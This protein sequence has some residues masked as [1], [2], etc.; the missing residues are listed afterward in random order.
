MEFQ[1]CVG[2]LSVLGR[3]ELAKFIAL[4]LLEVT[5]RART[6]YEVGGTSLAAPARMRRFNELE[7]R[8]AGF[9]VR[10]LFDEELDVPLLEEFFHE[11]AEAADIGSDFQDATQWA[12]RILHRASAGGS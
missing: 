12:V 9:L 6:T 1:D 8:L 4:L 2:Q 10:L 5:V 7:H 11:Q 3:A